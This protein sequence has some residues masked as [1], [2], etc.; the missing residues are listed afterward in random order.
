MMEQKNLEWCRDFLPEYHKYLTFLKKVYRH[1]LRRNGFKRISTSMLESKDLL[2][3]SKWINNFI[4]DN[5]DKDIRQKPYIW[6]MRSYL[7]NN[8]NEKIQPL[9][10]Y[11]ME[12]FFEEEKWNFEEKILIWTEI[13]WEDDPIL[14]A[15]Q[16]F[17]NFKILKKIGIE[18]FTIKINST[19]IEKEKVKFKE[20]L[21]NFYENKRN[22]LCDESKDLLDKNPMLILKSK[23]EDEIILNENA[24][25]CAQKFL[26]K[27]SKNHFAKFKEYL[28]LLEI[29]FMEDNSI[30]CDD[31]NQTKSIW[32]FQL[33]NWDIIAAWHRHNCIAKNLW[34]AKEIPA[35]G[36]WIYT[37]KIINILIENNIQLKNKDEIDL[38]FVQLWDDAKKV[39]LPISIKAREA[40]I[41]TVISLW[42]PSMKEQMLKAQKSEAKFVVMVGIMEA[43]SW[44]FQV[45]NQEDWT[46]CEVKK[47]ELI[48]YIIWKIGKDH[49]DFY[50]PV[51]DLVEKK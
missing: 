4:L 51:K 15:I 34:E 30:V 13:I 32:E 42:T 9:Y 43:K 6:I 35:T 50:C 27:D 36:F 2:K 16:I 14:D 29:P 38:F 33:E 7:E 44:V 48:D 8:L 40:W 26:K 45:R 24:P 49:L 39:V 47:E 5:I 21:I 20:E 18:N 11:F 46:Q 37:E 1:E 12:S 28:E 25:K 41:N 10:F 23:N 17:I 3:K 19:W 22:I 31:E